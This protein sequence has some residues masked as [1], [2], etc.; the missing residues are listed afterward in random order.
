MIKQ[1]RMSAVVAIRDTV[2]SEGYADGPY[3]LL[4]V[5]VNV[6]V[7]IAHKC[8]PVTKFTSISYEPL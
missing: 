5:K 7:L 3:S 4:S 1:V 2:L 8:F 6:I